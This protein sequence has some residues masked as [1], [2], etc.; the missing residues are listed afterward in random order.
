MT[1]GSRRVSIVVLDR[2]TMSI[3]SGKNLLCRRN[4][5]NMVAKS[6]KKIK[7]K[8]RATVIH[9]ELHRATSLEGAS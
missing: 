1:V 6:N 8:L 7:E 5:V 4:V 3:G 9:L 2:R